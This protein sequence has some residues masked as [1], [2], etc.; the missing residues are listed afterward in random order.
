MAGL[1]ANLGELSQKGPA[2]ISKQFMPTSTQSA[3]VKFYR[4]TPH[5]AVRDTDGHNWLIITQNCK[6]IFAFFLFFQVPDAGTSRSCNGV[7]LERL[8]A[9]MECEKR[10]K[11]MKILENFLEI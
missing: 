2:D 7:V 6:K 4:F 8:P 10:K 9:E 11:S 5:I 1:L 3:I